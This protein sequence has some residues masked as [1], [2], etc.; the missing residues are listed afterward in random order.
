MPKQ[1]VRTGDDLAAIRKRGLRLSWSGGVIAIVSLAA[2]ILLGNRVYTDFALLLPTLAAVLLLMVGLVIWAIGNAIKNRAGSIGGWRG[3]F[4]P[5]KHLDG[6]TTLL[7]TFE[8]PGDAE[9]AFRSLL[10]FGER[11]PP[12]HPMRLDLAWLSRGDNGQEEYA[13]AIHYPVTAEKNPGPMSIEHFLERW[14]ASPEFA[15][16]AEFAVLSGQRKRFFRDL[17]GCGESAY[18]V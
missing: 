5:V 8:S 16:L 10:A 6:A 17:G 11:N 12:S 2:A 13:V 14:K 7:Y 9:N 1:G 18:V 4:L 3:R 15:Q